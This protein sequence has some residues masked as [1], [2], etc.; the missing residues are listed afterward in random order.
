[1]KSSRRR[2]QEK[3]EL[4]SGEASVEGT[5]EQREEQARGRVRRNSAAQAEAWLFLLWLKHELPLKICRPGVASLKDPWMLR[6]I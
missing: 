2:M 5:A 4:G 1:M 3:G 6:L